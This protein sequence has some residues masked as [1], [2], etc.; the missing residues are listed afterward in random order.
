MRKNIKINIIFPYNVIGGAFRSTYEISNRLTDLGYD[1]LVYFPLIPLMEE[2]DIFSIEGIKHFVRG[3]GRSLIRGNSIKWFD[4]NFKT[5]QIP[6]IKDQHIR[7]AD[8]I[9]SNHWPTA[10]PVFHLNKS[11]GE[12]FY[13][14]RDIEQWADYY[15]LEKKC[16]QLPMKRLVTTEFI[17]NFL[18]CVR[19]ILKNI[20]DI[21]V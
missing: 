14:I 8:I 9:I 3:M 19:I 18:I 21:L 10:F 15:H 1:I 13:F 20:F 2:K 6:F 17:K 11:K 4:I 7:D 16:F 5:K 12:K